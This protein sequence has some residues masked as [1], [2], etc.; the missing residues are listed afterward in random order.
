M[1]WSFAL[2]VLACV[3]VGCDTFPGVELVSGREPAKIRIVRSWGSD[4]ITVYRVDFRIAESTTTWRIDATLPA[5]VAE[6]EVTY[7][8]VPTGFKQVIPASGAP[9]AL[10]SFARCDVFAFNDYTVARLSCERE[11][12]HIVASLEDPLPY[13]PDDYTWRHPLR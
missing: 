12:D 11:G 10:Q 4:A 1:R 5:P 9:P 8:V 6:M 13:E 2:V 3:L 7:G